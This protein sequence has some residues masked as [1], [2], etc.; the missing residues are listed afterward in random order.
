MVR[1]NIRAR[2]AR[3]RI[4]QKKK[5][6]WTA[7]EKL[8]IIAYHEQGHSKRETANKFEIEPKQLRDWLKNKEKLMKVAPYIQKLA[9][10]SRPK[11]P[12]LETEL[13]DWFKE[14]R[15]QLKVVTRY[16]IQ[17]KARSFAN[18]AVYQDMYTNINAA[19]FSQKWVDGFMTRHN[20]VNRR[21]TTVAQR[22]P[23]DYVEL[24]NSFLS[25]ILYQRKENQYPLSLIGNMDETPLSFNLPNSTTIE[26]RGTKTV[27]I[28][29]TGHER[30]NFTVV[31]GC[32]A[33]GTKLP[34]VIIFKLV[35]VPREEFPDGVIIRANAKGW[36]NEDEMSWWVENVWTQRASRASNPKSLLVLD[37]FTAHRTDTVKRR[38]YR[39]NTDI[40]IIPGGLTSRLQPLDVS[41]NK[42]FK[43]KVFMI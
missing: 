26:Q 27:S 32:L 23:D 8:M 4:S 25:Y 21:K 14:S 12:E 34:P 28:L 41:L 6:Q 36:M 38:F 37:A 15:S 31:L 40:A 10:G 24:Q 9:P 22:L 29:S 19:K 30:S 3:A 16:M 43:A 11:Y 1:G 17:A 33:D 42:S 5:R 13:L 2:R 7:R 18:R 35:N 20:L 39:K